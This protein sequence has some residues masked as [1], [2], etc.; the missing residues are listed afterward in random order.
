MRAITGLALLQFAALSLFT[1]G[2]AS[3]ATAQESSGTVT[4]SGTSAKSTADNPVSDEKTAAFNGSFALTGKTSFDLS[5]S[6]TSF[7]ATNA[8]P[9]IPWGSSGGTRLN[10]VG[11]LS[12]KLSNHATLGAFVGGSPSSAFDVATQFA[13]GTATASALV[14]TDSRSY[15]GGLRAEFQTAGD[16]DFESDLTLSASLTDISVDQAIEQLDTSAITGG[17]SELLTRCKNSHSAACRSV[18]T[19][20]APSPRTLHVR[21][22]VAS[23]EYTATVAQDTDVSVEVARHSYGG[24]DPN[25][26]GYFG[27]IVVG[28]STAATHGL[29]HGRASQ[30]DSAGF[31]PLVGGIPLGPTETSVGAGLSHAF[32]KLRL[33]VLAGYENYYE[34][35]ANGKSVGGTAAV[36]LAKGWHATLGVSHTRGTDADGVVIPSTSVS[37]AVRHGP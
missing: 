34:S 28:P 18:E 13:V 10:A 14:R 23:L 25:G 30:A 15:G 3:T 26:V 21:D 33:G 6:G 4:L 22:F 19:A 17:V 16:S 8:A 9:G 2:F 37:L 29:G 36:E 1:P 32:G 24:D 7:T 12:W 5:L 11:G 20:L 35:S 31:I 27:G